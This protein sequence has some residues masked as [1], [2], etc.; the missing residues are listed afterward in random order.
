MVVLSGVLSLYLLDSTKALR[1]Q[2]DINS[3]D[4]SS[5][6]KVVDTLETKKLKDEMMTMKKK[7]MGK[8]V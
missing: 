5:R 7:L 4:G 2:H 3:V 1:E 8:F 6:A